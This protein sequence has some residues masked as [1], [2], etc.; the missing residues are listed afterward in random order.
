MKDENC[1][2]LL[3]KHYIYRT[4]YLGERLSKVSCK[5]YIVNAK[6]IEEQIAKQNGKLALHEMVKNRYLS[7]R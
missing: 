3:V 2:V 4:R 1:I 7:K 6:Q 5:N